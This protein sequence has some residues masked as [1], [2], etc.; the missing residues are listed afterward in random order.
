MSVLDNLSS[1]TQAYLVSFILMLKKKFSR[2]AGCGCD[3]SAF[4]KKFVIVT[5][6][7]FRSPDAPL[8]VRNHCY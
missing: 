3:A 5:C 6:S 8:C 7:E 2:K 4:T 1:F